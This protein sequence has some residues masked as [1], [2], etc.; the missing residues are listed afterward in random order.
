MAKFLSIKELLDELGA[1]LFNFNAEVAWNFVKA[2]L[3]LFTA[4]LSSQEFPVALNFTY[5]DWCSV[6]EGRQAPLLLNVSVS[7]LSCVPVVQHATLYF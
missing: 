6:G 2:W 3:R 4:I 5:I 1:F 7:T